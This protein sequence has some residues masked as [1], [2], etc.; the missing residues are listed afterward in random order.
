M[1]FEE[2]TS[3][4]A[5]TAAPKTKRQVRF[6]PESKQQAAAGAKPTR[7]QPQKVHNPAKVG[8]ANLK[9]DI[10]IFLGIFGFL[11]FQAYRWNDVGKPDGSSKDK[12]KTLQD[13]QQVLRKQLEES[14]ARELARKRTIECDLFLATSSIPGAGIGIFAGKRFE[15]GDEVVSKRRRFCSIHYI[16]C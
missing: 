16:P 12:K 10:P 6:T 9:R 2:K 4:A 1:S 5:S 7:R 3:P 11:L 14:H 8:K 15:A 13:L